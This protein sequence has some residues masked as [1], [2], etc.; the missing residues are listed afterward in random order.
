MITWGS[1]KKPRETYT[2]KN[3]WIGK[4]RSRFVSFARKRRIGDVSIALPARHIVQNV[5]GHPTAEILFTGLNNGPAPIMSLAGFGKWDWLFN[6]V[7]KEI[8]AHKQTKTLM[9]TLT[10]TRRDGS[11]LKTF[12]AVR[13]I[14][15][16]QIGFIMVVGWWPSFILRECITCLSSSVDVPRQLPRTYNCSGL[17][18]THQHTSLAKRHL[19]SNSWMITS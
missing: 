2:S 9:P 14:Q 19:P 7:T 3:F 6:L 10:L 12:P 18:C 16:H 8:G 15:S 5:A 1:G 11:T 4:R 13:P 17:D